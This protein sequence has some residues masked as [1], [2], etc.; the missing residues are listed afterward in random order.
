MAT[1]TYTP[2]PLSWVSGL[3]TEMN[4]LANTAGVVAAAMTINNTGATPVTNIL[5]EIDL[6]SLTVASGGYVVPFLVPENSAQAGTYIAD[7]D[8]IAAWQ[9]YP[10]SIISLRAA[11]AAQR[12]MSPFVAT[13]L[14][15]KY[16]IG[17]VSYAGNPFNASGS[18]LR[19]SLFNAQS[20]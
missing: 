9:N 6:A 14:P 12:Q 15:M 19:Y 10:H 11:T 8:A 17:I 4:S 13:L 2:S 7:A 18:T 1:L 5:F 3:T 16:K 20:V